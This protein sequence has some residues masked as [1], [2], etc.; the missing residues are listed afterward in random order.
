LAQSSLPIIPNEKSQPYFQ[1]ELTTL[2]RNAIN[3]N[4]ETPEQSVQSSASSPSNAILPFQSL[5]LITSQNE[6]L[7]QESHSESNTNTNTNVNTMPSTYERSVAV[8]SVT[9]PTNSRRTFRLRI[10]PNPAPL[11]QVC[12]C[13]LYILCSV[14]SSTILFAMRMLIKA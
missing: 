5:S 13:I 1:T 7:L 14:K 6:N 11:S 3:I 12:V 9:T 2:S 4:K 10:L 8:Q